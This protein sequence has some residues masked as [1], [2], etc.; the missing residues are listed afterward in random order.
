RVPLCSKALIRASKFGKQALPKDR[1]EVFRVGHMEGEL[2]LIDVRDPRVRRGNRPQDPEVLGRYAAEQWRRGGWG[3][4]V[5]RRRMRSSRRGCRGDVLTRGGVGS[6]LS[7]GGGWMM[8]RALR[9]R[10]MCSVRDS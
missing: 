3:N 7:G 1:F 10:P 9:S 5:G 2:S 6:L 8:R 4:V